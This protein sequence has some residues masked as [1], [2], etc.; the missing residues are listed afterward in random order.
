MEWSASVFIIMANGVFFSFPR[1]PLSIFSRA[2]TAQALGISIITQAQ[3][4]VNRQIAQK[5]NSYFSR[6]CATLLIDNCV[7]VCYSSITKQRKRGIENG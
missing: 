1:S 6:I 4:F 2:P 3:Q 7:N 5:L